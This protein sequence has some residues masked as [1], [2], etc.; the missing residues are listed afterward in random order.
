[1]DLKE[2]VSDINKYFILDE[3]SDHIID[4]LLATAISIE[5]ER[6][7]WIMIV[8]PPSSGKTTLLKILSKL[9]RFHYIHDLTDKTLLSGHPLAQGGKLFTEIKKK[10]VIGFPD[11]TTVLSSNSKM[12]KKIFNQLRIIYDGQASLST[13]ID[14]GKTKI[15]EGK[16]AVISLVTESIDQ[17]IELSSDLGERFL[18]YRH[19]PK[20]VTPEELN[21]FHPHLEYQHIVQDKVMEFIE[22]KKSIITTITITDEERNNIY[23]L[24]KLISVGRA[25][26]KRDGYN[27]EVGQIHSPEN[28]FRLIEGLTS[29]YISS[30]CIN[31]DKERS[32]LIIKIIALNSIPVL[33]VRLISLIYSKS[34]RK[35]TY[36]YL[37]SKIAGI[38]D[39]KIRR[40]IEDMTLQKIIK[41]ET[42]DFKNTKL[43]SFT[44]DFLDILSVYK[45][46]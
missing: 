28:P 44:E 18:Y 9:K 37:R 26:V 31:E 7:I 23:K 29:I 27:R 13:G 8:S 14:T 32:F 16:V 40:T 21:N 3:K 42:T 45:S 5:L 34:D 20:I 38:S 24:A 4:L 15:W 33:R 19:A 30:L 6:P 35:V 41:E 2:I 46:K 39:S 12:K 17:E 22:Q 43:Y 11:F 10:G 36:E 25:K 1:M